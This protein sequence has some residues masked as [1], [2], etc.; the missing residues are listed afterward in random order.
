MNSRRVWVSL[1]GVGVVLIVVAIFGDQIRQM[2]GFG[3]GGPGF[4][5]TQWGV[6]VLGV[7]LVIA[8][9]WRKGKTK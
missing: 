6:L 8:G 7:I 4:G 1:V 5:P 3:P 2:F 9:F